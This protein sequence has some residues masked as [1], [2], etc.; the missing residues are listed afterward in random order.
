MP[1]YAGTC[2]ACHAADFKPAAHPRVLKGP[3]YTVGEL[4]NCSGACHLYGGTTS[5]PTRSLPGP[6]HRVSDGAFKR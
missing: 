1:A 6:Y 2:A 5:A 4:A 3:S